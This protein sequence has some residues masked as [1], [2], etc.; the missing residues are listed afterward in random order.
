MVGVTGFEHANSYVTNLGA[1][2]SSIGSWYDG[3]FVATTT[4]LARITRVCGETQACV[5]RGC[6]Q[7]IQNFFGS[8]ADI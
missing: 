2:G 1:T 8:E 3:S 6:L 7:A 5:Q 4:F